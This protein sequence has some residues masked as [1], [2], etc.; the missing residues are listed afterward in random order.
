[1]GSERMDNPGDA[2]TTLSLFETEA[3]RS[4]PVKT[5]PIFGQP[6]GGTTAVAGCVQRLGVF[7]G[8]PLHRNLEDRGF[9]RPR[10]PGP[11]VVRERN[12]Q[13]EV[14]GWKF[15]NAANYIDSLHV[16]LRNPRFVVVTR[17]L[18]ANA[19]GISAR[20]TSYDAHRALEVGLQQMQRNLSLIARLRHPTLVISYEKLVLKPEPVIR[21]IA[22]FLCV[23]STEEMIRDAVNFVRPGSYQDVT[24]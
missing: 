5:Y 3:S 23:G 18:A 14:W 15:P 13:R 6:R 9:A 21:D 17:D 24:G 2:R 10:G 1:M 11:E 20:D 19:I 8:E 12:A 22:D 7:L 16:A 4:D